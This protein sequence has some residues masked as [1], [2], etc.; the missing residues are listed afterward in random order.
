MAVRLKNVGPAVDLY[1]P[2]GDSRSLRV[3]EGQVVETPGELS[4]EVD[5]AYLIGAG[6]DMRA[7]SKTRWELDVPAAKRAGAGDDTNK[8]K[9]N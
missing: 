2:A 3:E 6:D 4:G 1:R 8:S 5:D 9:E 7:W